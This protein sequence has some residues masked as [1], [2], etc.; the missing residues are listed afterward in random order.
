MA[1]TGITLEQ[2]QPTINAVRERIGTGSPNTIHRHLTA[3]RSARP[4][5]VTVTTEL[6]TSLTSAIA[7][8][9]ERA[10]ASARA[11]IESKLVQVQTEAAELATIGED[12]EA[13]RDELI[14][15]VAALTTERD[16]LSGKAEQQAADIKTQAE[17]IEREQQAA[18]AA[19]V[20]LARA[21]LKIEASAEKLADQA[22]EVQRLRT[23]LDTE[24]QSRIIAEQQA[25]VLTA[26]LEAMTERAT[27]AEAKTEQ[28]EKQSQQT[29]QELNSTRNQVQAQ[30]IALDTAARE[31]ENVKQQMRESRLEA[32]SASD[33]AAE[34]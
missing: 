28:Q 31:L 21:Q 4:Q 9:I 1:R 34:L 8:E 18:E 30:Q 2:V 10:A 13:E 26:K 15:Q 20:E 29:S 5:A 7:T 3:W 16:T 6:P 27:K 12:L 11:E 19:R 32:K 24:T 33:E 23:T 17:R 22:A 14:E 25:A